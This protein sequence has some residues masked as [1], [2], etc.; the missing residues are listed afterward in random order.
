MKVFAYL[1]LLVSLVFVGGLAC[2][3]AFDYEVTVLKGKSMS[4][5]LNEGDLIITSNFQGKAKPGMIVTFPR[6]K[7]VIIHRIY[8]SAGENR[9]RTKGDAAKNPD[10]WLVPVSQIRG[11]YLFKVPYLGYVVSFMGSPLYSAVAPLLFVLLIVLYETK[12]K[13]KIM[14]GGGE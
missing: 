7:E 14:E 6:N 8:S 1:L 9:I 11:N 3:L 4:P 5:T 13:K 10:P 12:E 2:T